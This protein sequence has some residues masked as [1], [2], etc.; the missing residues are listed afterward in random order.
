MDYIRSRCN[1]MLHDGASGPIISDYSY[2]A[3]GP[4]AGLYTAAAQQYIVHHYCCSAA[5]IIGDMMVQ[6]TIIVSNYTRCCRGNC[7]YNR[8][9]YDGPKAHHKRLHR[10]FATANNLLQGIVVGACGPYN[11]CYVACYVKGQGPFTLGYMMGL[12]PII[13][14]NTSYLREQ[15]TRHR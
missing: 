14:N 8:L 6:S 4:I 1:I 5:V 10:L 11:R 15:I 7:P 3:L 2:R 9:H 12:R 13:T